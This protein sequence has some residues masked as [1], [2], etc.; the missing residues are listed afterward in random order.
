MSDRPPL[1]ARKVRFDFQATPLHWFAGD[2][3]VTHLFNGLHMIAPVAERLFVRFGREALAHVTDPRVRADLVAFMGQEASHAAAHEGALANMR[4]HGLDPDAF[5]RRFDAACRALSGEWPGFTAPEA[6]ALHW[7]LAVAAA[8]EQLT[9]VLGDWVLEAEALDHPGVD[10]A[11]RDLLRWHGAEEIEHR[12]VMFDV[13]QDVNAA[14]EYPLRAAAMIAV[15]PMIVTLWADGWARL[16]EQDPDAP[17][18]PLG[19]AFERIVAEGRAPGLPLLAALMRYF[20]PAF[21][22]AREGAWERAAEYIARSPA[23]RAAA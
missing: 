3:H 23:V 6:I 5:I 16:L 18:I 2:A 10:P 21:H 13:H 12:S 8:G 7:R 1:K 19:R 20:D 4:A 14:C 22:P 15:F 11:M 17:D 9:C